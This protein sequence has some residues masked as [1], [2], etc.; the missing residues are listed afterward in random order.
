MAQSVKLAD[1]IMDVV[2][3]E[4]AVQSRSV[5]GQ[6]AHWV[7]IGRAIE[8][9]G[10]YDHHNVTAALE[11]KLSPDDLTAGEQDVWFELFNM[12]MMETNEIEQEFFAERRR[13]GVGVGLS[14]DGELVYETPRET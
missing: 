14:E 6:L 11:G 2:R 3:S 1:D 5:A 12:K 8:Q 4:S 9:S 7:K 13:R 10:T